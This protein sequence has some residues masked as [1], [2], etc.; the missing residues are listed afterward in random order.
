MAQRYRRDDDGDETIRPWRDTRVRNDEFRFRISG[1]KGLVTCVTPYIK[2]QVPKKKNNFGPGIRH[3]LQISTTSVYFY[4]FPYFYIFFY[5]SYFFFHLLFFI[6]SFFFFFILLLLPFLVF[7]SSNII[8]ISTFLL[9]NV[10]TRR[11]RAS[12]GKVLRREKGRMEMI[13]RDGERSWIW[14]WAC[15]RGTT[16]SISRLV[17]SPDVP[18]SGTSCHR[19]GELSSGIANS[20]GKLLDLV[21]DDVEARTSQQYQRAQGSRSRT[22]SATMTAYL[23]PEDNQDDARRVLTPLHDFFF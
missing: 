23:S 21:N 1:I 19:G 14:K 11:A 22:T 3:L 4:I 17:G 9:E 12:A 5:L 6:F 10:T 18:L 13:R 7:L 20:Y 2:E 8:I 16:S 15:E